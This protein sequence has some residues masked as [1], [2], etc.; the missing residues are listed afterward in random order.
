MPQMGMGM[1]M[2]VQGMPSMPMQPM[3]SNRLEFKVMGN[4]S[5]VSN[6]LTKST[7]SNNWDL[8]F[9]TDPLAQ[10]VHTITFTINTIH[11]T[12]ESGLIIGLVSKASRDNPSLDNASRGLC[13]NAKGFT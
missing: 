10:G 11:S 4:G 3:Q 5:S 8:V 13:L 6:K 9:Y 12:D 1:P 7:R 2:G